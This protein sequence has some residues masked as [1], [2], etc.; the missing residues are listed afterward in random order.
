MS[1]NIFRKQVFLSVLHVSFVDTIKDGSG[2]EAFVFDEK[3]QL[4]DGTQHPLLALGENSRPIIIAPQMTQEVGDITAGGHH[5]QWWDAKNGLESNETEP[6]GN[7]RSGY[8]HD[9]QVIKD[10]EIQ[11]R[12]LEEKVK[13]LKTL[14]KL[15]FTIKRFFIK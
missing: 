15:R 13:S 3:F 6:S 10:Q 12:I 4:G 5:S 11:I 9:G 8:E 1:Q 14:V 7:F 2:D